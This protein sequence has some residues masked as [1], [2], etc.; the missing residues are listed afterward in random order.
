MI[1][2]YKK[3]EGADIELLILE[4]IYRSAAKN[5]SQRQRDLAQNAGISLGLVNS[6][7]KHLAEKGWIV[8][9][10]QNSRT[11]SYAISVEGMNTLIKHSYWAFK[12]SINAVTFF[13]DF[14][15]QVVSSA[16]KNN[17]SSVLLVGISDLEFIVEY[18]CGRNGI[19]FFKVVEKK[20]ISSDPG[21]NVYTI[22][23][24]TIPC[25][26]DYKQKNTLYLSQALIKEYSGES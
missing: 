15:N 8:I 18:A 20:P 23:S 24:E 4:N 13:K 2:E 1:K 7:L 10:K 12:K 17:L 3:R 19:S 5:I 21:N 6:A 11:M 25:P 16:K 22:F 26:S 9:Q 14:L